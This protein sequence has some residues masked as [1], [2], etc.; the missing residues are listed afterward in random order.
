MVTQ[1]TSPG[2]DEDITAEEQYA[3]EAC[4]EEHDMKINGFVHREETYGES[5]VSIPF[6]GELMEADLGYGPESKD[7][8]YD[9]DLN[10]SFMGLIDGRLL[11]ELS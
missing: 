11:V 8:M 2:F 10:V 5:V 6:T 4:V 1:Q 9:G 3:I 7:Y